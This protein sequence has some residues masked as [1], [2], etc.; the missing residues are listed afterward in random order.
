VPSSAV[1]ERTWRTG[2]IVPLCFR[3]GLEVT[4]GHDCTNS[5]TFL[6]PTLQASLL[7]ALIMASTRSRSQL[8][9]HSGDRYL[10]NLLENYR[11]FYTF[12]CLGGKVSLRLMFLPKFNSSSFLYNS[13]PFLK[14]VGLVAC[15]LSFRITQAVGMPN[16]LICPAPGRTW[17]SPRC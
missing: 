14:S 7:L 16:S 4:V 13:H 6:T 3:G 15:W 11:E 9:R 10:A 8:E 5:L 2:C 17:S 12:W 1:A